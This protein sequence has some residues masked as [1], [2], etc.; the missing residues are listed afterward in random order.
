MGNNLCK[1]VGI[2]SHHSTSNRSDLKNSRFDPRVQKRKSKDKINKSKIQPLGKKISTINT[3]YLNHTKSTVSKKITKNGQKQFLEELDCSYCSR[4]ADRDKLIVSKTSSFDAKSLFSNLSVHSLGESKPSKGM[5]IV[6]NGAVVNSASSAIRA[7]HAPHRSITPPPAPI[8]PSETPL[9]S[10]C[11][12]PPSIISQVEPGYGT[13]LFEDEVIVYDKRGELDHEEEY[14]TTEQT[15]D[16][17]NPEFMYRSVSTIPL[18]SEMDKIDDEMA[19]NDHDD[20]N[21]TYVSVHSKA[22]SGSL[23]QSI[24]IK[25]QP[26]F[27]MK[28]V[29]D[30]SFD[31]M[32]NY[33]N[34]DN[35]MFQCSNK[36]KNQK[37]NFCEFVKNGT[38]RSWS[39]LDKDVSVLMDTVEKL[40]NVLMEKEKDINPKHQTILKLPSGVTMT[41]GGGGEQ[42]DGSDK[43]QTSI[44]SH[45]EIVEE[46]KVSLSFLEKLTS[47]DL[48]EKVQQLR[49]KRRIGISLLKTVRGKQLMV[50]SDGHNTYQIQ[51]KCTITGEVGGV[52]R[53]CELL[54]QNSILAQTFFL[55]CCIRFCVRELYVG[56]KATTE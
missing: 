17:S 35:D 10:E 32:I 5:A 56:T 11:A 9:V 44:E 39:D 42:P 33:V 38:G 54:K 24:S 12:S 7:I 45:D 50:F 18:N 34:S 8:P 4:D 23:D 25:P 30:S 29:R 55:P 21:G 47:T 27:T 3:S 6:S 22:R 46:K 51:G 37:C 26:A 13:K 36:K 20:D 41:S 52:V 28:M 2:V 48:K 15:G 31:S 16:E 14:S 43:P 40:T 53:A 49:K 1:S 19:A